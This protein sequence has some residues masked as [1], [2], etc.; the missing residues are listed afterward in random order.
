M[1]TTDVDN[2]GDV[3]VIAAVESTFGDPDERIVWYENVDGRGNFGPRQ[4]MT[5]HAPDTHSIMA[6]DMDGDGDLDL[7]ATVGTSRCC[8]DQVG[9]YEQTD[10][11]RS[12][13]PLRLI[14]TFSSSIDSVAAADLDGDGDLDL[15]AASDFREGKIAW[16][17]NTD[18]MGNFGT[19][20]A[21]NPHA[22]SGLQIHAVDLAKL[23]QLMLQDGEWDGKRIIDRDWVAQ[24]TRAGQPHVERCGLLWWL[25][26]E[27]RRLIDDSVIESWREAN[28]SEEIIA[29]VLPLKDRPLSREKFF[30][31]LTKIFAEDAGLETWHEARRRGLADVK[32][33]Y[34]PIVGYQANGYLGQY[35]VILKDRAIVAVRQIRFSSHKEEE[36]NFG[37][38]I[39][40]VKAL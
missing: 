16:Y 20:A 35:L 24:S 3:D 23:G 29:K 39:S 10:G 12:L 11:T 25:I 18:G 40:M 21:G 7:L 22:M 31:E 1:A 37:K 8:P 26:R 34:G 17:E 19:D 27:K 4:D 14:T 5:T 13:G 15:L 28:T 38:F 33:V 6:V 2:D 36:D 32:E 30:A 9:W